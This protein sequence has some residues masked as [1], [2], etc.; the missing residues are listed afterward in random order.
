MDY[1]NNTQHTAAAFAVYGG[2]KQMISIGEFLCCQMK[3]FFGI[4]TP[5]RENRT[6]FFFLLIF[7]FLFF[8]FFLSFFHL[9][10]FFFFFFFLSFS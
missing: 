5:K 2:G 1:I 10:S 6:Q 4:G 8:F 9:F 3:S 7:L